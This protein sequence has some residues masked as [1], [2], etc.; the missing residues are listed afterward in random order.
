ME[1][2]SIGS[3]YHSTTP[4]LHY[5]SPDEAIEHIL[6]QCLGQSTS[7]FLQQPARLHDSEE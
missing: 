5:S 7:E 6:R 2:W 3:N 4:S 1:Y